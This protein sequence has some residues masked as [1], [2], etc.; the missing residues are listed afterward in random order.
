[1]LAY[2]VESSLI[3][4]LK[5]S[6]SKT[7]GGD[8]KDS[9]FQWGVD[10]LEAWTDGLSIIDLEFLTSAIDKALNKAKKLN[11]QLTKSYKKQNVELFKMQVLGKSPDAI[12][13]QVAKVRTSKLALKA[14]E[15]EVDTLEERKDIIK[16]QLD[17]MRLMKRSIDSVANSTKKA[18]KAGG[19]GS[20]PM[21]ELGIADILKP[22][23]GTG[24]LGKL[25]EGVR[26]TL[27]EA[28]EDPLKRVKK[29][30]G[31]DIEE[32]KI[33]WTRFTSVLDTS[34]PEMISFFGDIKQKAGEAFGVIKGFLGGM[35]GFDIG[36]LAG[37]DT[38]NMPLDI[39]DRINRDWE[40]TA[41]P[42]LKG[43]DIADTLKEYAV[44]I[45]DA[46]Q[47]IQD[48]IVEYEPVIGKGIEDIKAHLGALKLYV[49][50]NWD[51]I[52][53]DSKK[54][55]DGFSISLGNLATAFTG[56]ELNP[57]ALM[58][59]ILTRAA[60]AAD[61]AMSG[62]F[63]AATIFITG[64]DNL[65]KAFGTGSIEDILFA[66]T[67]GVK[68]GVGEMGLGILAGLTLP[69]SGA[70][71][72]AFEDIDGEG[73]QKLLN[74]EM[75]DIAEA[76]I[77]GFSGGISDNTELTN[78]QM[79][80]WGDSIIRTT[81]MVLREHSPS[82]VFNEIA[83]NVVLGF[84]SGLEEDREALMLFI[85]EFMDEAIFTAHLVATNSFQI[86]KA[87]SGGIA[88]GIRDGID[89]IIEA[90]AEAAYAAL[91]GARKESD[92]HSPS[93]KFKELGNDLIAGL[94][95]GLQSPV[96]M[97]GIMGN[98][99]VAPITG[100]GGTVVNLYGP[101]VE[102]MVVSNGAAGRRVAR[103]I[104]REISAMAMLKRNPA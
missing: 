50:D 35:L 51:D 44:K 6:L 11:D 7:F 91:H 37:V 54:S 104:S 74:D 15:N 82:A 25:L 30:W 48:K 2:P 67:K 55:L 66:K 88:A 10:S 68:K 14:N 61:G 16:E 101:V 47:Y 81:K 26:A 103:D 93:R 94:N 92:T 1:M 18:S 72:G 77:A 71:S 40:A 80:S 86:G 36:P 84:I 95:Q 79:R 73:F 64:V 63:D 57:I 62:F 32:I 96:R 89:D 83:N 3:P 20:D 29:A 75:F 38:S 4:S 21:S 56:N 9:L 31:D 60:N 52:F 41:P 24:G 45:G 90:A 98:A 8:V 99:S 65:K 46:F 42:E 43:W 59:D 76:G 58:L 28:L 87:F 85:S 97:P 17:L 5:E 53:D 100:G 12:R 27:K 34:K 22:L 33:A 49:D 39:I 78:T 13:A 70:L 102:N 69:I 23:T 19:G